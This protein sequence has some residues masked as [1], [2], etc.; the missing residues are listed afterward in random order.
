M[1]KLFGVVGR[2]DPG[3]SEECVLLK[4]SIGK[5][6]GSESEEEEMAGVSRAPHFAPQD[7]RLSTED[8]RKLLRPGVRCEGGVLAPARMKG[9]MGVDDLRNT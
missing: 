7:E 4:R 6:T 3:D 1:S 5:W 2:D 8:R 9:H